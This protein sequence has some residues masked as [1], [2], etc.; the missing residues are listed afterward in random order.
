[1]AQDVPLRE[2]NAQDPEITTRRSNRLR[3]SNLVSK[4]N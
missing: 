1:M 3:T 2:L 4:T